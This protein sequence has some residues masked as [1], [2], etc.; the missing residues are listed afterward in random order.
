MYIYGSSALSIICSWIII[1]LC[2]QHAT[3]IMWRKNFHGISTSQYWIYSS[4]LWRNNV[5][6]NIIT[7]LRMTCAP[8]GIEFINLFCE[9]KMFTWIFLSMTSA[10]HGIEFIHLFCEEIMF[11]W[12]FFRMSWVL[13]CSEFVHQI[14][15]RNKSSTSPR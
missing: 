15:K 2:I 4:V 6:M 12:V 9:E 3:Y 5:H 1:L 14:L 8:H 11:T 13:H 7:F 10:P